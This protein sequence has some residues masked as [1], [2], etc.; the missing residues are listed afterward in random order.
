MSSL[1]RHII[2]WN[3]GPGASKLSL[4]FRKFFNGTS[5]GFEIFFEA[6]EFEQDDVSGPRNDPEA[7]NV[8]FLKET[9]YVDQ[10]Y[11]SNTKHSESN[12]LPTERMDA[13][14]E[15]TRY[16]SNI[17]DAPYCQFGFNIWMI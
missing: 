16:R 13:Y 11:K 8:D 15:W 10:N 4:N 3:G 1:G 6:N 17:C 14:P 12:N 2:G 9:N 7:C 5:D